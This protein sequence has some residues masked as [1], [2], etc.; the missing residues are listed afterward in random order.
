MFVRSSG[1]VCVLFLGAMACSSGGN[2]GPG[3]GGSAGSGAVGAGGAGTGGFSFDA[4]LGG[5]T[6]GG[7]AGVGASTGTGG[8]AGSAPLPVDVKD[9]AACTSWCGALDAACGQPKCSPEQDCKI[10]SGQCAASTEAFLQCQANSGSFSCGADG[11][12]VIHNCKKDPSVCA[13]GTI[14]GASCE[15]KCGGQAPAGCYCD[16]ECTKNG[17]C[18]ADYASKCGGGSGGSGGGSGGG[19]GVYDAPKTCAEA[20]NGKGCCGWGTSPYDQ[21][22]YKCSGGSVVAEKCGPTG[23]VVQNGQAACG[24]GSELPSTP[25]CF[26]N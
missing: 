14:L 5:A 19:T 17:D 10:P 12:T 13:P 7:A 2:S 26:Q 18:C 4:G 11:H 24:D 3:A 21:I 9:S 16:S 22:A 15:G 25:N 6:S 1:L 20:N 23:C 8:S